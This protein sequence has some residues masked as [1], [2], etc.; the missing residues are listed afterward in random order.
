MNLSATTRDDEIALSRVVRAGILLSRAHAAQGSG[1]PPAN[2]AGNGLAGIPPSDGRTAHHE[3]DV[4][5]RGRPDPVTGYLVGI[6]D[7]DAI[8][9]RHVLPELSSMLHADEPRSPACIVRRLAQVLASHLPAGAALARLTWNPGPFIQHAWDATMPDHALLVERFEFSAAH[10]LHCPS[11]S[12]EENRR[13]FGKCNH[14]S[15]HGHN[16]RIAVGVR[17]PA[18]DGAAARPVGTLEAIVS[19]CVLARFDHRHLNVD[20]PEFAALNPSVENIAKVC[21]G[22]LAAPL[23]EAGMPIDHVTVW[24]TEKTSATYAAPGG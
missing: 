10:R 19:R 21:H 9:R 16:Y 7:V 2:G 22:L 13:V 4:G 20:C 1:T 8:V 17:V 11:L 12:D 23:A 15:G 6:Q 14:A 24:E 18:G 3:L 5:L